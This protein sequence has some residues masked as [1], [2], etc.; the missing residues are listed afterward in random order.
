MLVNVVGL[1]EDLLSKM[2]W[3]SAWASDKGI[4]KIK[5]ILPAVTCSVQ[6]T[7]LTGKMPNEHGIVGN[8]WYNRDT[9]EIIFWRQSYGLVQAPYIWHTLKQEFPDFTVANIGWWFNMYSGADYSLTPRPQYRANGLKI[10]DCYTQPAEWRDQLQRQYGQ[11]PLFSY[12][13]PRTTIKSSA[14]L[15]G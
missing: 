6:A 1:T 4:V 2:P 5:P 14:W 7:Y 13:G 10:Q 12:W 15:A 8:G 3:M 9:A 11:F